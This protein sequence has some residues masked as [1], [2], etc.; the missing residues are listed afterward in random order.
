[1]PTIAT[2][3]EDA[4]E[5]DTFAASVFDGSETTE[6]PVETVTETKVEKPVEKPAKP[7]VKVETPT[8]V[9]TELENPNLAPTPAAKEETKEDVKPEG[10]TDKG[11]ISFKAIKAEREEARKERDTFKME[12]ETLRKQVAEHAKATQELETLRKE[13]TAAKEQLTGYES[14]ITV[15]R[16]EATPRFKKEVTA[17]QAEIKGGTEEIAK[18]YEVPADTLMRAITETD[19]AK[20]ADLM[21][22]AI[23]D[24]KAVDRTEMVQMRREWQRV[25]KAADEMRKN[26]GQQ[27]EAMTRDEKQAQER[28]NTKTISDY[29]GAVAEQWKA[30]QALVPVI[31]YV[32][33]QEKWNEHLKAKV[34]RIEAININDLEVGEVAKMAAAFEALPEVQKALEFIQKDRDKLKE[35]V[36]ALETRLKKYKSTEPAAGGGSGGSGTGKGKGEYVPFENA[37]DLNG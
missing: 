14:E 9:K 15:T 17:P 27:L 35:E 8:E 24:M 12:T 18:R 6:K 1:M 34:T 22:E 33:G 2:G 30:I 31:R 19:P 32:E 29:R 21:E 5:Q 4:I 16:V 13:L 10:M 28:A 3:S 23:S 11:W 25:Q 37:V 7:E 36:T 20:G 26:A